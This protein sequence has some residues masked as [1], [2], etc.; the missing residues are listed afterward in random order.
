MKN[1]IRSEDARV[2][3]CKLNGRK[4]SCSSN[5][6]RAMRNYWRN[7]SVNTWNNLAFQFVPTNKGKVK[8]CVLFI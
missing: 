1:E 7:N 5:A 2:M 6:R 8:I 4:Y 3:T